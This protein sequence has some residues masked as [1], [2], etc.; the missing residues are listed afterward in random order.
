MDIRFNDSN[1][2]FTL[3]SAALIIHNQQLLVVKNSAANCCYT[4]GGGVR[5]GETTEEAVLR[6][7]REETGRSFGIER[8][9]FVQ[10]RFFT[11]SGKQHHEMVFF[12]LMKPCAVSIVHD[13]P[14]DHANEALCWLPFDQLK[15]ASLVPSFLKETLAKLPQAIQHIVTNE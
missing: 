3:R 11:A 5:I 8:L 4:I 10:E 14:T 15:A 7:C 13:Q 9:V 2:Q 1:T 12:Y 6:E